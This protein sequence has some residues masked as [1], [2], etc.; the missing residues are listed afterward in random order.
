MTRKSEAVSVSKVKE[1]WALGLSAS[2]IGERLGRSRNTISALLN[3]HG[4]T[5]RR[6]QTWAA[7]ANG[8][9]WQAYSNRSAK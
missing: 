6:R 9:A 5:S 3:R 2:Q 4:I 1:L 8:T 7:G